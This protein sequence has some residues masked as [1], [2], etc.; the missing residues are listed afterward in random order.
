M[1][2]DCFANLLT[3]GARRW[4]REASQAS[5]A[6]AQTC[7]ARPNAG[8]NIRT[9]HEL[10]SPADVTTIAIYSHVLRMG[11]EVDRNPLDLLTRTETPRPVV[12]EVALSVS[13]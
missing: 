5:H 2:S 6:E 10:L 11:G 12:R 7:D 3:G 8:G 9:L 1:D 13:Q 4:R